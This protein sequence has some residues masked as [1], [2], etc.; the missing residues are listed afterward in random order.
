[1]QRPQKSVIGGPH[2]RVPP[3]G[4]PW[5]RVW[6]SGMTPYNISVVINVSEYRTLWGSSQTLVSTYEN[7]QYPQDCNLASYAS[8]LEPS[9][10]TEK[11]R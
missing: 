5:F 6:S 7:T 8:D 4:Q 10:N 1:M 3:A 2:A 9:S 11:Y